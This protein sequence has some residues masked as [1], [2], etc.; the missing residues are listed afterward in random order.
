MRQFFI[1]LG[2]LTIF[3]AF[4]LAQDKPENDISV[5][6]K[7]ITDIAADKFFRQ[8]IAVK[9]NPWYFG[10]DINLSFGNYSYVGLSP[11][12]GYKIS[13]QFHVGA[14]I[15]YAHAWDN[16]YTVETQSNM[17]GGSLFA[18]YYPI[19]ELFFLLEPSLGSYSVYSAYS[20]YTNKAVPFIFAGAGLNYYINPKV[21]LTF[22]VKVDVLHDS[23]SPYGNEWHPIYNAGVGFGM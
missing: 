21:F 13:P 9:Q 16:R 19:K 5:D 22:Q 18:R 23:Q 15:S 17:Y 3:S 2:I 11:L 10:G 12:V 1:I 4:S 7:N 20:S 14:Q 6:G 8:E